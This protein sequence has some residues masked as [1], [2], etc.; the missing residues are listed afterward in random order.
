MSTQRML[1]WLPWITLLA[2]VL[3][4]VMLLLGTG[5]RAKMLQDSGETRPVVEAE[6]SRLAALAPTSVDDPNLRQALEQTIKTEYI[7]QVWLFAPDGKI[8]SIHGAPLASGEDAAERATVEVKRAL[9]ALPAGA[10]SDEQRM[11]VLVSSALQAEGEHADVFRYRVQPVKTASGSLAAWVGVAYDVNPAES[12]NPD[13][14][15]VITILLFLFGL[16]IYWISL[17]LWVW[18]DARQRGERAWI[19]AIFVLLGN[20]VALVAYLLVRNTRPA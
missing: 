1:K 13:A 12:G 9:D 7:S 18:L 5:Q 6:L 16:G 20:L 4:A 14:A 3:A 11:M 19:W 17:P 15:W 10:L 8:V 2:A